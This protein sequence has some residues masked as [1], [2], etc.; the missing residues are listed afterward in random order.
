[1]DFGPFFG[2]Y[3]SATFRHF[4]GPTFFENMDLGRLLWPNCQVKKVSYTD[5][6]VM[7]DSPNFEFC[8]Q[9][10]VIKP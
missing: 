8:C 9:F 2:T 1:M 10:V 4:F 6:L 3:F 5:P 7:M